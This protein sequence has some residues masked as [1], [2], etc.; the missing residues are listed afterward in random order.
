MLTSKY[1]PNSFDDVL[2]SKDIIDIVKSPMNVLLYGPAGSGK[3]TIIKTLTKTEKNNRYL[4]LNISEDRGINLIREEVMNF[5][6]IDTNNK[7]IILDEMDSLTADAQNTL[8]MIMD[9]YYND[10]NVKF[11]FVCNYVNN[12]NPSILSKCCCLR[13]G[14]INKEMLISRVKYIICKE[15]VFMSEKSISYIID[16]YCNDIRKILNA[17]ESIKDTYGNNVVVG[18][19]SV[20]KIIE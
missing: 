18:I 14:S 2:I 19:E 4:V 1:I 13:I 16:Y 10:N 6:D 3:T 17:I 5:I 7:V 8:N 9:I 11:I 20:K 15:K 12:I